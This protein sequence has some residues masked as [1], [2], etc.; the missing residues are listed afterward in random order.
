MAAAYIS[1]LKI[2]SIGTT[3]RMTDFS[4]FGPTEIIIPEA[5]KITITFTDL[6]SPSANIFAGTLGGSK[7]EVTNID[8]TIQAQLRQVQNG[9]GGF[10]RGGAALA[11]EAAETLLGL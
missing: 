11:G 1:N 5:Y 10:V 6:V 2:D 4:T 7:I 9:V 3:R 8:P